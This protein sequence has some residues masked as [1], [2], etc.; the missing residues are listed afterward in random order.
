MLLDVKRLIFRTEGCAVGP[1][2]SKCSLSKS[3]WLRSRG[4]I[5]AIVTFLRTSAYKQLYRLCRRRDDFLSVGNYMSHVYFFNRVGPKQS[6][7]T[8]AYAWRQAYKAPHFAFGEMRKLSSHSQALPRLA[9]IFWWM[10]VVET[11]RTYT[12]QINILRERQPRFFLG[13]S[14]VLP[15]F[16]LGSS[17]LGG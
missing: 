5:V 1:A 3:E 9:S 11:C 15:R 14:S 8:K 2:F 12:H 6:E 16:F 4:S 10:L 7:E 13:S 17:G